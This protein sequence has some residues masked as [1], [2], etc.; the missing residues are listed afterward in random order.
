MKDF[1]KNLQDEVKR[2]Q[3]LTN[4]LNMQLIMNGIKP[5]EQVQIGDKTQKFQNICPQCANNKNMQRPQSALR[6]QNANMIK[7]RKAVNLDEQK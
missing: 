6:S 1:I 5:E 2:L 3:N 7:I 4:D